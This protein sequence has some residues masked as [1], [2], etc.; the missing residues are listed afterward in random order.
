MLDDAVLGARALDGLKAVGAPEPRVRGRP[1]LH[2]HQALLA[3]DVEVRRAIDLGGGHDAVRLEEAVRRV[4]VGGLVVRIGVHGL[5]ELAGSVPPTCGK[6]R[7]KKKKKTSRQSAKGCDDRENREKRKGKKD[8][9]M[10][11][12]FP[13][14]VFM[15]ICSRSSS[16][17]PQSSM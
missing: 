1:V 16:T 7:K 4:R 3:V 9:P 2:H 10:K 15:S 6:K 17:R 13:G 14:K 5:G 11:I 12:L 8:V